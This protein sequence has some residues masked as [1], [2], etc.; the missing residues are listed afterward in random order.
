MKK[1]NRNDPQ[2]KK[3]IGQIVVEMKFNPV[4]KDNERF[5]VEHW[6]L[7]DLQPRDRM[8][9][10][11]GAA[12]LTITLQNELRMLKENVTATLII[13]GREEEKQVIK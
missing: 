1:I 6:T 7:I 4:K 13:Y 10:M 11:C 3:Y 5:L 12:L 9:K 8:R 2:N